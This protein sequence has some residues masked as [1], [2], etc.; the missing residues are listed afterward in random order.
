MSPRTLPRFRIHVDGW[1]RRVLILT[2]TPDPHC[3]NCGGDGGFEHDYGDHNGEYAGTEWEPC[4][5]WN[6]NRRWV[7]LPLPHRPRWLRR[8]GHGRDPW[9]PSDYSDE[10][11]F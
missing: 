5:C 8:R 4:G 6:E 7:L 3:T 11:P 10:P 9:G 1:S 2:D